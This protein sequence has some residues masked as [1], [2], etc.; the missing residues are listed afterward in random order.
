MARMG[1]TWQGIFAR[2]FVAVVL[3][4]ATYNPEGYSYFHWA[5]KRLP[6]VDALRVFLGVVLLV[7]WTVYVRATLRSLGPFGLFLAAA[8]F[9]ALLWLVVGWG[10][11]PANSVRAVTYLVLVALC[12]VL[13]TGVSWSHIRRRIS[14][15]VDVDEIDE[16]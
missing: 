10:I 16:D 15:Q 6:Q 8:F 3:V 13:A 5:I 2:F 14:G 4:F 12:G 7:G 9:G 11:V 1:I